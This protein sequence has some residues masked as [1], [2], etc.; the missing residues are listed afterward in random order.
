M[1]LGT[2][3]SSS[4]HKQTSTTGSTTKSEYLAAHLTSKEIVFVAFLL[5]LAVPSLP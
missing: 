5:V 2:G 4:G 3:F 1:S